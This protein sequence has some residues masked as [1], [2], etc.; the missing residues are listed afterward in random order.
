MTK[1]EFIEHYFRDWPENDPIRQTQIAAPC[2][3]GEDGCLGWQMV[4]NTPLSI[5]CYNE[6]YKGDNPEL[7]Y[8]K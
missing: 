4:S 7:I 5:M 8:K 6:L 1:E 2:D 3:C